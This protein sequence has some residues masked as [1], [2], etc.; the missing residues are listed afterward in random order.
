MKNDSGKEPIQA[1]GAVFTYHLK[2]DRVTISGGSPWV[3]QPPATYLRAM[4]PN[5]VL[6]ISPKAGSFIT[7]GR[8]EMGGKLEPKK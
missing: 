7:E 2:E 1:S 6:R 8:W 3:V 5:L 4:Q